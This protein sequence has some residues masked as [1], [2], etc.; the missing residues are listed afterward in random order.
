MVVREY[1][2]FLWLALA[3]LDFFSSSEISPSVPVGLAEAMECPLV[4]GSWSV[5]ATHSLLTKGSVGMTA[6]GPRPRRPT[7]RPTADIVLREGKVGTVPSLRVA[8]IRSRRYFFPR[9]PKISNTYLALSSYRLARAPYLT[10]SSTRLPPKES[11][12]SSSARTALWFPVAGNER[13]STVALYKMMCLGGGGAAS[14][15]SLFSLLIS[16]ADRFLLFFF[17]AFCFF[18]KRASSSS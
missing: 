16:S 17:L 10:S 6:P 18:A 1:G 15:S 4:E 13:Y 12:L 8:S 7:S 3:A 9:T 5:T 14:S 11:M 2:G